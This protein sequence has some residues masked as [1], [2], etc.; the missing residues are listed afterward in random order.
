MNCLP[1]VLYSKW[2]DNIKTAWPLN[3][4]W[5]KTEIKKEIRNFLELNVNENRTHTNL[6]NTMKAALRSK[7]ID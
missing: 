2:P 7:F 1:F 5:V 4:K 3:E 6:R